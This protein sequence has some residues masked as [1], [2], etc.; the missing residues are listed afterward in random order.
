MF[1]LAA[2]FFGAV[3]VGVCLSAFALLLASIAAL[4]RLLPGLLSLTRR[5]LRAFLI[6]SF[7]AY[8]LLLSQ[9]APFFQ[10]LVGVD[11]LSGPW[12]AIVCT[13]LSVA[14]G[15]LCLSLAE[16]PMTVWTIAPFAG[17]GLWVGLIW[18]QVEDAGGLQLGVRIQ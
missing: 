11:V 17:H 7:R 14:L 6:L 4:L 9:L 12:R 1:R 16:L 2:Q 8:Y 15:L 5:G 13:L 10:R 3:L 18:H